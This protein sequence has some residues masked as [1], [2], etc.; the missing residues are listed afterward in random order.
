[1]KDYVF[2]ARRKKVK[3]MKVLFMARKSRALSTKASKNRPN[4]PKKAA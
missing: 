3:A 2:L 1:M 4:N